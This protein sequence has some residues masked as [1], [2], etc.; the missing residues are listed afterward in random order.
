V[1]IDDAHLVADDSQVL[2]RV[3]ALPDSPL[4]FN[5]GWA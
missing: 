1:L 2:A 3:L 4:L 5:R